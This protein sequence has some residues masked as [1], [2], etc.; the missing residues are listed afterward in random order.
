MRSKS[1]TSRRAAFSRLRHDGPIATIP[2]SA[3]RFWEWQLRR[4][5]IA[6]R[7]AGHRRRL[8]GPLTTRKGFR[9]YSA[10]LVDADDRDIRRRRAHRRCPAAATRAIVLHGPRSLIAPAFHAMQRDWLPRSGFELDARPLLERYVEHPRAI[11]PTTPATELLIPI[12]A[13]RTR[14]TGVADASSGHV[15][16]LLAI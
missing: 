8:A 6:T 7:A 3:R 13:E 11:P 5:L 10:V 4:A 9:Y 16:V 2:S 12:R 14:S 1:S 15:F